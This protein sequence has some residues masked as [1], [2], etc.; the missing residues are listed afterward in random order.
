MAS[1]TGTIETI[2]GEENLVLTRAINAPVEEVFKNLTNSERLSRWIGHWIG[3]PADKTVQFYMT[4]EGDDIDPQPVTIDECESPRRLAVTFPAGDAQW[5]LWCD[6][7]PTETG[8]LL[9]F[10][11]RLAGAGNI[12]ELGPGWEYYLDRMELARLGKSTDLAWED[13]FPAQAAA[14]SAL[15]LI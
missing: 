11:Q 12:S 6:L 9:R 8:T 3:D 15:T 4:A 10:G 5:H 14:Y 7:A 1:I 2:D 13:Y